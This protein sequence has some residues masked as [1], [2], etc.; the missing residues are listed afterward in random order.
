MPHGYGGVRDRLL[1]KNYV[2]ED[3][4]G[5]PLQVNAQTE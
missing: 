1:T 2:L 4:A 5:L 3:Q